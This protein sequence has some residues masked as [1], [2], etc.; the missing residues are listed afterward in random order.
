MTL[1]TLTGSGF[2]KIQANI[3]KTVL[4]TKEEVIVDKLFLNQRDLPDKAS[5]KQLKNQTSKYWL[6]KQAIILAMKNL[7][8][9]VNTFDKLS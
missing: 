6:I 3:L 1:Q 7:V 9:G 8:I 4:S 2:N 5:F